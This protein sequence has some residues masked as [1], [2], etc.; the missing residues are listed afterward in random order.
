MSSLAATQADGYY[1]PPEYYEAA[2][3][4]PN[5]TKNQWYHRQQPPAA[6]TPTVRFELPYNALCHHCHAYIS[7]G[8]RY[9]AIKRRVADQ[10]EF[11]MKCRA[12]Q[13][14][15][16]ILRTDPLHQ[17]FIV[18]QG[19]QRLQRNEQI[20]EEQQ[21]K[22][23]ERMDP[24]VSIERATLLQQELALLPQLQAK[25]NEQFQND[26]DRNAQ[27][28]QIHRA[29]RKRHTQQSQLSQQCGWNPNRTRLLLTSRKIDQVRAQETTYG[30]SAP[31]KQQQQLKQVRKASIFA[32][33][34][35]RK[36]DDSSSELRPDVVPSQIPSVKTVEEPRPDVNSNPPRQRRRICLASSGLDPLL[37]DY[38]S[39]SDSS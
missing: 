26:A 25:R 1:L 32:S 13:T 30:R 38:A 36:D 34:K 2:Q 33:N 16:F 31:Q 3:R 11:H 9:N 23:E 21:E 17:Q 27:L 29:K 5:L 8:T 20:H 15:E 18:V 24:V 19:L 35:Q 12:C 14:Q 28:R 22:K 39:D 6:T 37:A 7:R 10:W 4:N